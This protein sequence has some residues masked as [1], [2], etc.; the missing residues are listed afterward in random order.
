[1]DRAK[2]VQDSVLNLLR[3]EFQDPSLSLEEA[4]Q[5]PAAKLLVDAMLRAFGDS[6]SAAGAS[7]VGPATLTG[8]HDSPALIRAALEDHFDL[9]DLS[10]NDQERAALLAASDIITIDGK[11]R[12]RLKDESRAQLLAAVKD[13]SLYET[14]LASAVRASAT[15]PGSASD[16]TRQPSVWLQ[17][18]LKGEAVDLDALS[19]AE[20]QAAFEGRC[21]LRL[22]E[23]LSSQVPPLG[24]LARRVEMA[25]LLEPLRLLVGAQGGWKGEPRRDRF[26]GRESELRQLRS[27]VDELASHGALEAIGRFTAKAARALMGR[28][29][30]GLMTIEARGGLGK[31]TLLA[32]FVLDHALDQA[33][34]FPFAYLDFDRAGIDAER[35]HQLLIEVA[36]QVRLQFPAAREKLDRLIEDIRDQ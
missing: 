27:F 6:T 31:S 12:L 25:E 5:R 16:T 21:R 26:V 30:P 32:K 7:E 17:R 23:G 8:F 9:S 19:P 29:P 34:P 15:S 13:S 11:R 4:L 3:E 22:V 20:L 10:V 14:L 36:R 28:T 35:P 1:M 2:D 33:R 18:F 24:E